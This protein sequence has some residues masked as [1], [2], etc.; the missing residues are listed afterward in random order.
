MTQGGVTCLGGVEFMLHLQAH[1]SV[2]SDSKKP[3]HWNVAARADNERK[4]KLTAQMHHLPAIFFVY[5]PSDHATTSSN[6]APGPRVVSLH[7]N[8]GHFSTTAMR[9][10]SPTWGLPP[11]CKQAPRKCSIY[12]YFNMAPGLSGQTSIVG[13]VFFVSILTRKP[14]SHKRILI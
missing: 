14:P 5:M 4:R 8:V 6:V 11:P 3:Q 9:D 12:Q 2:K 10:T 13:V 7:V 1:Q